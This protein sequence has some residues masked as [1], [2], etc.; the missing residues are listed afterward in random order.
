[1]DVIAAGIVRDTYVAPAIAD[2]QQAARD[3]LARVLSGRIARGARVAIT[4]GS[5]GIANGPTLLR[6]LAAAVRDAGG[7]PFFVP[8][9][10]SHGGGTA[11][12]QLA[13]LMSLGI[14]PETV[15]APIVS[16]MDVVDVGVTPAGVPVYCDARAARADA[17]VIAN[18]IKPHTHFAGTIESG[19]LKMS[20]I[21]LGKAVGA[22]TYHAAFT[23]HGY[24]QTIR[25]VAAVMFARLP[26]V[27][28]VGFVDDH[29][30]STHAVEAFAADEIVAG[31]ERLLVEARAFLSVL[32][33]DELDLLVVDEMGK[34]LSGAGMDTNVTARSM[35]GRTQKVARPLIRQ[36]FVRDLTM[37]SHGNANGVG[38]ADFCSRRLADKIDWQATY[39]NAMTSAAPAGA[40]LP[41]V[42][43][44]DR[45]A[46]NYA[47]TAA[48]VERLADARVARIKNTLHIDAMV[49]SA[50]ALATL[51]NA[52][53]YVVAGDSDALTFGPGDDFAGFPPV[54]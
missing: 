37:E 17:I 29:R 5:R 49:V 48:G 42:C 28:G 2:P 6:G 38:I 25:E 19:M 51:R 22:A 4:A 31:E 14:T 12:G 39:L 47:L 18:R 26:V 3:A 52:E 7:E 33:F 35:D 10:G 13:M 40:R 53:R 44:N 46:V 8:A 34:E 1:M 41:V 30:G 11:D 50:A 23:S 16:A 32:P 27:A 21:G 24:E 45:E 54:A 36:L 20:A 43:A 15:G 9:M